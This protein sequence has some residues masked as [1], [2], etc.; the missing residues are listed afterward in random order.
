MS[1]PTPP[2]PP[3]TSSAEI[4]QEEAEQQAREKAEQ[5]AKTVQ[6]ILAETISTEQSY[7]NALNKGKIFI[8]MLN[9]IKPESKTIKEIKNLCKS[10]SPI[11]ALQNTFLKDLNALPK[12]PEKISILLEYYNPFFKLYRTYAANQEKLTTLM[13]A[14]EK[15]NNGDNKFAKLLTNFTTQHGVTPASILIQPIQ[16]VPRYRLLLEQLQ[17]YMPETAPQKKSVEAALK[18]ILKTA[19]EINEAIRYAEMSALED[20]LK[21]TLQTKRTS[22]ENTSVRTFTL[23]GAKDLENTPF[24]TLLDEN[25]PNLNTIAAAIKKSFPDYTGTVGTLPSKIKNRTYIEVNTGTKEKPNLFRFAIEK[26]KEGTVRVIIDPKLERLNTPE[27]AQILGMYYGIGNAIA[28]SLQAILNTEKPVIPIP[29]LEQYIGYKLAPAQDTT[30]P[31]PATAKTEEAAQPPV[32]ND[33]PTAEPV[34]IT[35][36][37]ESAKVEIATPAG[38]GTTTPVAAPAPATTPPP[39]TSQQRLDKLKEDR[40]ARTEFLKQINQQATHN[41]A[42]PTSPALLTKQ[43]TQ[44]NVQ[45]LRQQ[46]Q[47]KINKQ[48]E[49]V[50]RSRIRPGKRGPTEQ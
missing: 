34:P 38:K 27:N 41:T 15:K 37:E 11:I 39:L 42:E 18:S 36:Q 10:L 1:T 35:P 32:V 8:D 31:R 44:G 4:T 29:N 21:N 43:P 30:T 9:S 25:N 17:K 12:D 46:Y 49:E 5:N 40:A 47:E 33:K 3:Q 20:Q 14:E 7:V 23:T 26:D 50:E 16:R 28:K 2:K 45:T 22:Q 24:D 48:K 19:S 6:R 13:T